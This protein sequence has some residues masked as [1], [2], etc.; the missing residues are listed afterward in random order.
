MDKTHHD[1]LVE[2]GLAAAD[3]TPEEKTAINDSLS[4]EDVDRLVALS[5]QLARA[6]GCHA[7][8]PDSL[9]GFADAVAKAFSGDVPTLI[10]VRQDDFVDGYP[11][12]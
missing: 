4:T 5:K 9:D 1:R 7:L 6:F 10:E 3:A 12:Q 8:R 11:L 2:E